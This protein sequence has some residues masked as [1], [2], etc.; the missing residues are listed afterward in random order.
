MGDNSGI[1]WT[2]STWNPITGCTKITAG[3]DNCYAHRFA[4]RFRGVPGHPFFNGFDLTLKP[5]RLDQPG[6]WKRPRM[7]FVNSMSD[8][9]H[10]GVPDAYVDSVFDV[11]EAT[12]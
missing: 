11:M 9:F 5:D 4:E 2:E 6:R 8:L 1:E 10:K 12:D 3:C 7:I